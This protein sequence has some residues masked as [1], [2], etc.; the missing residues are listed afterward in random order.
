MNTYNHLFVKKKDYFVKLKFSEIKWIEASGSYST[1]Y[2]TSGQS[3]TLASNLSE[4]SSKI[5]DS[6]FIRVHRSYLINIEYVDA[7]IGN[8][9]CIGTA[10]I[11][12]SKQH[13]KDVFLLLNVLK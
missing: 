11:P 13:K 9:I 8:T 7:F 6:N 5:S 2:L 4:I 3:I 1:I 12:I 10:R